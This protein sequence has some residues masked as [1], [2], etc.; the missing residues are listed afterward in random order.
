MTIA[1]LIPSSIEL[2]TPRSAVQ[3]S[4]PRSADR[5]TAVAVA[6]I[7]HDQHR[8]RT[9][10]IALWCLAAAAASLL[11]VKPAAAQGPRIIPVRD[12]L[13]T[14]E[15]LRRMETAVRSMLATE[16]V[17]ALDKRERDIATMYLRQ[18]LA[19]KLTD[20]TQV[21]KINES[22]GSIA[23][24][25][26]RSERNN[27]AGYRATVAMAAGTLQYI[28][29]GKDFAVPGRI[30]A[31]LTLSRLNE[32]AYNISQNQPPVPLRSTLG[33]LVT[34][35][36]DETNPDAVRAAA[37][38]GLEHHVRYGFFNIPGDAREQITTAM[39]TLVQSDP[40]EGR[41]ASAH[42]FLKRY[43]LQILQ[44]LQPTTDPASAKRTATMLVSL[45]DEA[46]DPDL[47]ALFSAERLGGL[48]KRIAGQ[49]TDPDPILKSWAGRLLGTVDAELARIADLTP[50]KI[51]PTQPPPPSTALTGKKENRPGVPIAGGP[52][53]GGRGDMGMMGME[54]MGGMGMGMGMDSEM[55][56]MMGMEGMG[57]GMGM[58]GMGM[59][60][61]MRTPTFNPQPPEVD[62]SRRRI[63]AVLQQILTGSVGSPVGNVPNEP[64]GMLAAV[65]DP[66]KP[67]VTGFVDRLKT[68]S[69]SFNDRTVDTRI[70]W[71]AMLEQQ[72]PAL[73]N[74]AGV[75]IEA[76]E[77]TAVVEEN[78]FL[79]GID[80]FNRP[81]ANAPADQPPAGQPDAAFEGLP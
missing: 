40:P 1:A 30:V 50:P 25:I 43:A 20:P 33:P 45:C 48:D 63:D 58:D 41:D 14:D 76:T 7:S 38:Q 9:I 72:R 51:D 64:R 32:Q 27:T 13:K 16:D 2:A 4:L 49:V 35:Y 55:M 18:Y 66:Q 17:E 23:D 61:G 68:L 12:E 10:W 78:D 79:D 34:I 56:G 5:P 71:V 42:A 62:L 75:K 11:L 53:M 31:I 39:T 70:K 24:L 74:L 59:G 69:E 65:P 73:G 80:M 60:M 8:K 29:A 57:M 81:R 37:L 21:A 3:H 6:T 44:R 15:A 26:H 77:T 54:E 36:A 22:V 28:G 52:G 46:A 47:I 67:K 19:W